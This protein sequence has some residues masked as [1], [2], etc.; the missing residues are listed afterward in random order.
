MTLKQTPSQTVGPF[1]HYSLV[2]AGD[3]NILVNDDTRGQ[4]I[5]I[6]GQITDGNGDPISDAML[7]IWQADANGCFNHPEDPNHKNADPNFRGFG[8]APTNKKG[9]YTIETIKPG[10]VAYDE[11]TMQAPH[12]SLRVFGRGMLIHAYT[13][14]YFGDEQEANAQDPILNIVPE[15][16]RST[17]IAVPEGSSAGTYCLN[18]CLQGDNETVFFEP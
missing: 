14:L 3:E 2:D 11:T 18:I 8:R 12:I 9:I 16:R 10:R 7:E 17:L 6:K 15:A 1:F 4:R 5:T 13:R